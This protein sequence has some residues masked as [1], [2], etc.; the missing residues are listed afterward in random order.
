MAQRKSG[1]ASS[2]P[3]RASATGQGALDRLNDSIDAAQ[4]ALKDLRSEMSRGSRV[5]LKDVDKTLRD[6]RRNV[7]RVSRTVV[8]D[9]EQVEQAARGRRPRARRTTTTRP[10]ARKTTAKR[11]T[12]RKR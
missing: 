5:L 12:A 9:L 11:S 7:R 6:A 8:K 3:A 1:A 10:A 4:A 2:S